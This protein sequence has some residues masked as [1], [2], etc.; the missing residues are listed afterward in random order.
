MARTKIAEKSIVEEY[1]KRMLIEMFA[2]LFEHSELTDDDC[3]ELGKKVNNAVRL[4][5][6]HDLALIS[7]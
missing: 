5:I 6:E 3:I 7:E 2:Q 1:R 4:R